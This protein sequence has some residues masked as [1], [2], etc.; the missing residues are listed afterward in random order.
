MAGVKAIQLAV[1]VITHFSLKT[2]MWN[3]FHIQFSVFG[4]RLSKKFC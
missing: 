3:V 4:E 2:A 1:T